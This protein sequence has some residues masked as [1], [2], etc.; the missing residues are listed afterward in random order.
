MVAGNDP[1]GAVDAVTR[2]QHAFIDMDRM[3]ASTKANIVAELRKSAESLGLL[4]TVLDARVIHLDVLTAL[5]VA[6]TYGDDKL[7]SMM[8]A[9]G[10]STDL[11]KKAA[12]RIK[13]ST[14]GKM[15]SG[16]ALGTGKRGPKAGSNT[17]AAFEKLAKIA[18]L[19]DGSLNRAIGRALVDTG[20][21]AGFETEKPFGSKDRMYYSDLYVERNEGDPIRLEFMWRKDT[22]KAAISNYVL[23]KLESYGKAVGLIP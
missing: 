6:R 23:K 18:S 4:G 2:S 7:K 12:D 20:I 8:E 21:I 11:D 13:E 14:L 15:L 10:M 16:G 5:A 9:Q 17:N 1:E 19:D 3:M 22:Q